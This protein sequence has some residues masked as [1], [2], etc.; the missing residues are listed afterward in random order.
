MTIISER[1][2]KLIGAY[3]Q[4]DLKV[5][6]FCDEFVNIYSKWS[7]DGVLEELEFSFSYDDRDQL[8]LALALRKLALGSSGTRLLAISVREID[9][10]LRDNPIESIFLADKIEAFE[11][12]L[13]LFK[14]KIMASRYDLTK[15]APFSFE[16]SLLVEKVHFFG[17]VFAVINEMYPQFD[18]ALIHIHDETIVFSHAHLLDEES[19]AGVCVAIQGRISSKRE[20]FVINWVAQ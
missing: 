16:N 15:I 14:Q 7:P 12:W 13:N 2:E 20:D 9:N 11:H 3:N 19:I 5:T 1:A 10:Y 17:H 6:T 4:F 8:I 18:L